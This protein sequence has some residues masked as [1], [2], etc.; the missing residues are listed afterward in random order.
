MIHLDATS[1]LDDHHKSERHF[2]MA[3]LVMLVI[4]VIWYMV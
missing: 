3:E 1:R 2:Y 4:G